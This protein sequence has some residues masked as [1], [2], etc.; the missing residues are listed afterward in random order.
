MAYDGL[1]VHREQLRVPNQLRQPG[2]LAGIRDKEIL[3]R[4]I[5]A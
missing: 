4:N 2:D 3:P 5:R 1:K